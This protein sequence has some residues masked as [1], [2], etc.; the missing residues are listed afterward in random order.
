[1]TRPLRRLISYF[2]QH[3]LFGGA[4]VAGPVVT[5]GRVVPGPGVVGGGEG[6]GAMSH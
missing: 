2:E 4:V 1:M 3:C 6:V 5:G